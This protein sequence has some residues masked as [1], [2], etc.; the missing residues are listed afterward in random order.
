MCIETMDLAT[1]L[2]PKFAFE[3]GF[4]SYLLQ[5]IRAYQKNPGTETYQAVQQFLLKKREEQQQVMNTFSKNKRVNLNILDYEDHL[6]WSTA[7]LEIQDKIVLLYQ[8]SK[9]SSQSTQ[10]SSYKK[11]ED[12]SEFQLSWVSGG[13]IFAKGGALK[14]GVNNS[15]SGTGAIT[16]DSSGAIVTTYIDTSVTPYIYYTVYTFNDSGS[17]TF[18]NIVGSIPLNILAVG[19]GGGGGGSSALLGAGGGAGGFVE[20]TPTITG[21]GTITITIGD[22]GATNVSGADTIVA[23]IPPTSTSII[24]TSIIALGGGYG[25]NF[26]SSGSGGNGGSGGGT[27]SG[28]AGIAT[29]PTSASGGYG[30]PG[31]NGSDSIGALNAGGGGGAGAQGHSG[32]NNTGD[33][34]AGGIGKTST[35]SGILPTT[36]YAGGGGGYYGGAGG[37]G[38][39]GTGSTSTNGGSGAANTGGGGGGG[40]VTAAGTGGSGIVII[41]IL[42]ENIN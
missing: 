9:Y 17:I 12:G 23:G 8:A 24:S 27:G 4:D 39:G 34:G 21:N 22:G 11:F 2:L 20:Q 42:A 15:S 40:G 31:G 3:I 14:F 26:T 33:A 37:Q 29:Q 25:G 13:P 30:N 1:A 5:L 38:G 7:R 19:G 35:L 10:G 16:I 6:L 28:L 36:F 18:S 32:N 41:T